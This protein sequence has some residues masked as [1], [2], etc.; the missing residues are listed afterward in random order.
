MFSK[1]TIGHWSW[2]TTTDHHWPSL[3]T[4]SFVWHPI[5]T[6]S[7]TVFAEP[8]VADVSKAEHWSHRDSQ[9]MHYSVESDAT[10]LEL[11]FAPGLQSAM[12][13][14]G[15]HCKALP[16]GI[17]RQT[18]VD[19]PP[20]RHIRPSL[21]AHSICQSTKLYISCALALSQKFCIDSVFLINNVRDWALEWEVWHKSRDNQK[22]Y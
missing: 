14:I 6:R 4:C 5:T 17:T 9:W 15:G 13:G 21:L 10:I 22:Q 18:E 11:W 16:N 12:V 8:L 2:L 19:C 20:T 7:A 3:A 1:Y